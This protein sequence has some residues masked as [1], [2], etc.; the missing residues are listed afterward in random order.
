MLDPRPPGSTPDRR[1]HSPDTWVV[2]RRG[3]FSLGEQ[4]NWALSD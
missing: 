3:G 1:A 2:I 4:L